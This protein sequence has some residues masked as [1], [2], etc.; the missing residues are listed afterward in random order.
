MNCT[1]EPRRAAA[2]RGAT[3]RHCEPPCWPRDLIGLCWV[4]ASLVLFCL[5]AALPAGA[6]QTLKVPDDFATIQ[7]AIDAAQPGDAVSVRAGRYT[8]AVLIE[9]PLT[10]AGEG[11]ALTVIEAPRAD[12]DV[13]VVVSKYGLVRVEGVT[14]TGGRSGFRL[15]VGDGASAV[16]ADSMASGNQYGANIYGEGDATVRQTLLVDSHVAGL[17]LGNR[18][19]SAVENEIL[20]GGDGIVLVGAGEAELVDNLVGLTRR[21]LCTFTVACQGMWRG[22]DA[23]YAWRGADTVF[24]GTVRGK[25]NRIYGLYADSCPASPGAPW[26]GDFIDVQWRETVGKAGECFNSGGESLV[27]RNDPSG[28]LPRYNEGLG[29][30]RGQSFELYEAYFNQTIGVALRNLGKYEEAL[31]AD[32]LARSVFARYR[33]DT[34][35]ARV[36]SNIGVAYCET[37][38][39]EEALAAFALARTVFAAHGMESDVAAQDEHM[40]SAY[41]AL[42]L[43]D[44]ALSC[45]GSARTQFAAEGP[46]ADLAGLDLNEGNLHSQM[47]NWDEAL[48]FYQSAEDL[49]SDKLVRVDLQKSII[50]LTGFRMLLHQNMVRAYGGVGRIE[51][52]LRVYASAREEAET[53][54]EYANHAVLC[55]NLADVYSRLGGHQEALPLYREAVTHLDQQRGDTGSLE[56]GIRWFLV[57]DLARCLDRL[58]QQTDALAAYEEAMTVIES[59]RGGLHTEELKLAWGVR[60]KDV[61]ESLIDLLYRRGEGALGLSY[62][63]RCRARTFLDLL[64]AGPVATLDNVTGMGIGSEGVNSLVIEAD[65]DEMI[66]SLPAGTAA[67]EYFVTE[68]AVFVW[69][70]TQA[71]VQEPLRLEI[72]RED[73]ANQVIAFR[74]ALEAPPSLGNTADEALLAQ[75]RDL[76][77]LLVQPIEDKLAGM[78]HVVIIPSGLLHYLPFAAL[79]DSQGT[80]DSLWSTQFAPGAYFGDQYALSYAPSLVALKYAQEAAGEVHT[81]RLLLALADPDSGDPALARLP[82]ARVE[83]EAVAALFSTHE[84]YVDT[85]AT[86]TVVQSQ[87]STASQL[88]LSTHGLFNAVN[89]MYSYLVLAPAEGNDGRLHTYE[90]FGLDLHADLVVLSACETLL[91]HLEDMKAQTR[92]VRGNEEEDVELSPELM[93][94]LTSGDEIVGLTRA[95]LYAGTPSVLSSLWSVYSDATKD[96]MVAFYGYQNQGL[97]KAEALQAAQRDVRK[98]YPHP[99]FWA[100]FN[101]VGDWK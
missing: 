86:E 53:E 98:Q 50:G 24:A 33:L 91:P 81:E 55:W 8:E 69:V 77:A 27:Y 51:D 79:L 6:A 22:S 99:V 28:A 87:S 30:L 36:D 49:L 84:V 14:V 74:Q 15:Q 3:M 67:V 45:L 93:E 100:A 97:D 2:G 71:G 90:V 89:P 34:S 96:L 76:Y 17:V 64:A 9:K 80:D 95:F 48:R 18:S 54:K 32:R 40:A 46:S 38:R 101:L 20:L 5:A 29:Y 13:I 83:A 42:G 7:A 94:E 52:A 65:L 78:T 75:A 44:R 57:A 59:L 35:V 26:P 21:G 37:G 62:A 25:G 68:N 41:K 1:Q 56:P 92:A 70:I 12:L 72:S 43:Y 39:Y 47:G 88:L 11:R 82:E 4:I 58:G 10:L 31:V 85:E 61:Y 23:E 63:E 66:G 73:L 19:A 16:I 60:T